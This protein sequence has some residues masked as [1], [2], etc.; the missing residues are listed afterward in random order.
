NSDALRNALNLPEGVVTSGDALDYSAEDRDYIAANGGTLKEMEAAA[1]GWVAGLHGIPLL[2][3]K[4][5]TDFVDHPADTAKQFMV[6]YGK[7]VENL[8]TA[9]VRVLEYLR[10]H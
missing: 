9:V 4:T 5:V 2:P 3:I 1:I 7:S 6:N 10:D 8:K